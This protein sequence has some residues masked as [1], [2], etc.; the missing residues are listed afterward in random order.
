MIPS[1]SPSTPMQMQTTQSPR[2][3]EELACMK[4]IEELRKYT[5]MIQRMIVK[6]GNEG[7]FKH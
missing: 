1:P 4:K 2:N 6:I 3:P 7:T 5:D